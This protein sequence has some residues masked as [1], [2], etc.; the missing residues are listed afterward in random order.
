MLGHFFLFKHTHEKQKTSLQS[1]EE[2][3]SAFREAGY[4]CKKQIASLVF[5]SQ[6]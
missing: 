3:S 5:T 4:N 6:L 1:A 2:T